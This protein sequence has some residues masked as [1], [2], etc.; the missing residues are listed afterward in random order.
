MLFVF[1]VLIP[2]DT[3]GQIQHLNCQYEFQCFI[4]KDNNANIFSHT[5]A[6]LVKLTLCSEFADSKQ[7]HIGHTMAPQ[8]KE[9]VN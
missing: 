2:L 3:D 6:N 7:F 8:S 5:K 9:A 1:K 4:D